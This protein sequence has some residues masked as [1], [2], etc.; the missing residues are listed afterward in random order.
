MKNVAIRNGLIVLAA[1]GA[2][3]LQRCIRP[4]ATGRASAGL[5]V[6]WRSSRPMG[7]DRGTLRHQHQ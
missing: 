1:S 2:V 5:I 7:A 3:L 4:V 6:I